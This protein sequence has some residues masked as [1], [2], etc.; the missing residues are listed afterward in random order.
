[1]AKYLQSVNLRLTKL[2]SYAVQKYMISP[3]CFPL[4]APHMLLMF[5]MLTSVRLC[6]KAACC[7]YTWVFSEPVKLVKHDKPRVDHQNPVPPL[8]FPVWK[9]CSGSQPLKLVWF[10]WSVQVQFKTVSMCSEKHICVPPRL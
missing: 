4:C 7:Q 3:F 10:A 9:F 1:M 5:V 8:P 2:A 6:S